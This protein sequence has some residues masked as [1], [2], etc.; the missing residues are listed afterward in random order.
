VAGI[1]K[2]TLRS[3]FR[4]MLRIRRFEEK[5][6]ELYPAQDMRTPVHL[7][8]GQE[9]I[10]AGVCE[11][12]HRDDYLFSTHRNHGHYLAKGIRVE[13]MMA[14]F[15]G[16][17]TGCSRGKGGS[18]HP[19][20]PECGILGTSAIVGGGIPLAVG[21]ALASRLRRDGKISVTLFGDGATDEGTF[22]ES[23]NFA[24]LK[25]LPVL[26][27]CENNF[28]ATNSPQAARQPHDNIAERGAGYHIPGFQVDGNDVL[29]V[30][31]TVRRAAAWAR[32][33]K[34]PSLIE[35]R[36]YRWKGHVG[37]DCDFEKGCRPEAELLD[38][39]SRCPL[40]RFQAYVLEKGIMTPAAIDNLE[41][42]IAEELAAAARF[43]Q[44]SP[45]PEKADLLT[46]V[47]YG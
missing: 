23:L 8:V 47:Y 24:S 21:T 35:C 41:A 2:T 3:L 20:A 12:L 11:N 15:Y 10:A 6:I 13:A 9:A 26:F 42:A 28:Y 36:T 22:H 45:W 30:Y 4:H 44:E 25:Q 31:R 29:Q 18:M 33:G 39:M 38:W 46:D 1:S 5:I 7:C 27:V 32:E 43:G 19:V 16:R 37:P 14:E 34:G 40:E 17:V